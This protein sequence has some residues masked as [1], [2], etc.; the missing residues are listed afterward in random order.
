MLFS[1]ATCVGVFH[2]EAGKE[3]EVPFHQVSDGWPEEAVERS[4]V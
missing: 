2:P 1:Q 3:K 4:H